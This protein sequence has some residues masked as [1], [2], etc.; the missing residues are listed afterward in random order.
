MTETS[1]PYPLFPSAA[2]RK[3]MAIINPISGTR[4][5][6]K[7]EELL[8]Q[9]FRRVQA[10]LTILHTTGPDDAR[11]MGR[12]AAE[13][14]YDLVVAVGGDGTVNE[15]AS[16]LCRTRTALGII[17]CGSGNG[18]ARTLQIPQNFEKSLEILTEGVVENC[19]YGMVNGIPFFC[20]FGLGFDAAVADSFSHCGRRGRLT[21]IRKAIEEY[22]RYRPASY[23]LF[24]N[25]EVAVKEAFLIAVCNVSQYGNNVY[26]APGASV[27]DGL[28][29]IT[30]V[31]AGSPVDTAMAGLGMLAGSFGPNRTI[32]SFRVREAVITRLEPGI[33]QL[34]GEPRRMADKLEISCRAGEL[35]VMVPKVRHKFRPFITPVQS[36]F[37]DMGDDILH[38]LSGK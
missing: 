25:G 34:D 30:V 19:D 27:N 38:L 36:F 32:E 3:V 28:L 11:T 15:V 9:T 13:A 22:L 33:V 24:I 37:S 16:A 1:A 20:T 26:I 31:R 2:R 18:L 5:K 7:L 35:K 8:Q 29:D 10:D 6:E 21:Y 4:S 17:P 12:Q 14:G 23:A